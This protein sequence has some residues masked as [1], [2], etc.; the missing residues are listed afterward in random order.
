MYYVYVICNTDGKMYV[1]YSSDL[2]R[3]MDQH[4]NGQNTSTRSEKWRLIYYEAYLAKA[5]AVRRE[6]T[7]KQRGQAKRYLKE[8]I[9]YSFQ[10]GNAELGARLK[11]PSRREGR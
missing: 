7:L 1:G 11:A 2:K 4:N 5:D 10:T 9:H 6:R 3:R 8:R